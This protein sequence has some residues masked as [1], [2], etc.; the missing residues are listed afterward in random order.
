MTMSI[1][2]SATALWLTEAD[3]VRSVTLGSAIDA[4]ESAVADVARG[5]AFNVPKALGTYGDG[6]SMHSLGSARP[7][8]GYCGYKNWVNTKLGAKAIFTLFSATDGRLL[9]VMEA[10]ALGKLRTA[11]IAGVG[12]RWLAPIKAN[13]LAII[14]SGRQAMA[15]IAAVNAVRPLSRIRVWSPTEAKRHAFAAEV[16]ACFSAD[17][18]EAPSLDAATDGAAIITLVTRATQPFIHAHQVAEGA[19]VNA[20]G[21][22]LP[23]NAEFFPDVFERAHTVAVDDLGNTQRASREF[24]DH[25][26]ARGWESVRTLGEI[27]ASGRVPAAGGITLFKAMGMGISDLAVAQLVYER[28]IEND[29]I[30]TMRV[31]LHASALLR[32][33]DRAT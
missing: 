32:F 6:S 10:N 2:Q 7:S 4:L 33:T 23:G 28:A 5:A 18:I 15:Q 16:Q 27:M 11:A 1:D 29:S 14:G 9:A 26:D 30:S 12:T 25:Y 13:E 8:A 19:H 17:V 21:A 24:I 20:M 22:I 31:P 3:V